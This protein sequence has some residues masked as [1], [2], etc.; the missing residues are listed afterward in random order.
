LGGRA[1]WTSPQEP[2]ASGHG[3]ESEAQGVVPSVEEEGG[4]TE[5]IGGGAVSGQ[6]GA[7]WLGGG[8]P[9]RRLSCSVHTETLKK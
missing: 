8:I 5:G 6:L 4:G 1:G 3:V 2:A 7:A 9:L